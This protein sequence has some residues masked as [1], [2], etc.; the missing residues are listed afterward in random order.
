M[1]DPV[2][3]RTSGLG[4]HPLAQVREGM[5]VVDAAGNDV[6]PVELISMGDPG[7]ATTEGNEFRTQGESLLGG[8]V[9]AI[10]ADIP[11]PQLPD[12]LRSRFLIQ[13]FMKID[14]GGLTDTDWYASSDMVA[15]VSGDTV[16]L[17][18]LKDQLPEE[19]S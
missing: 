2:V 10:S 16:R 12:P 15:G 9:R 1:N 18:V 6:G 4:A 5:R 19:A 17:S 7:A 14:G 8:I 11:E 3:G 13:G